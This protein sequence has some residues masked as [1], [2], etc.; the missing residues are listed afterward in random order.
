MSK[1]HQKH[2]ETLSEI[3]DLMANSSRF[4]SLSG[5]SGISAGILALIGVT[6]AYIYLGITPFAEGASYHLHARKVERWGMDHYTFFFITGMTILMLA[7]LLGIFFTTRKAKSKGQPIWD[8]L[9]RRLLWNLL[10]PLMVGGIFCVAL[11][12][13]DT[14]ALIAPTTLIFYGLAL[15]NASKY[16]LHD[17]R[18]LGMIEIGLGCLAL[19]NTRWGLEFWGVGFGIL[20]IVYGILMYYKYERV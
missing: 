18:Y 16:T 7:I 10:M 13:E 11:F 4:I 3:R 20:H 6:L 19:F 8:A 15:V 17:I 5:L 2:L 14:T 1:E 9:T 12:L